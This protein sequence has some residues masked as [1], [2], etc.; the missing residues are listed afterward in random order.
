M[1]PTPFQ[2]IGL[3]RPKGYTTN[4]VARTLVTIADQRSS[5]AG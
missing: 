3:M 1:I 5:G 4:K 2:A